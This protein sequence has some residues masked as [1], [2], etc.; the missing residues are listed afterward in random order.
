MT[1]GLWERM[2]RRWGGGFGAGSRLHICWWGFTL[3]LRG[4]Y[5]VGVWD[6]A[7]GRVLYT[8]KNGTPWHHSTRFFIGQPERDRR[9]VCEA[10][11]VGR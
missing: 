2:I 10:C 5:L 4:T 8:S 3:T 1:Y 11:H 7:Q 6:G 9:C